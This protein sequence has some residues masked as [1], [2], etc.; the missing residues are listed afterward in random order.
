MNEEVLRFVSADSFYPTPI[1]R[2]ETPTPT[3][4]QRGD[5]VKALI[6]PAI[7]RVGAVVVER[8]GNYSDYEPY[9][10]EDSIGVSFAERE[11]LDLELE[12][13]VR[14]LIDHEATVRTVVRWFDSTEQL[15]FASST[16]NNS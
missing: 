9:V 3:I 13:L 5:L 11:E 16:D 14:G 10:S 15:E 7:G 1:R 12:N 8:N 2:V 6:G 4:F